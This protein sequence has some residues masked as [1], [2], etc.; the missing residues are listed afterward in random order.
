MLE[1]LPGSHASSRSPVSGLVAAVIL[2]GAIVAVV[3]YS[4]TARGDQPHRL[5][6]VDSLAWSAPI[7]SSPP[8]FP[9]APA[10]AGPLPS[11]PAVDQSS[12]PPLVLGAPS[13]TPVGSSPVATV[14][15]GLPGVGD[16]WDSGVVDERPE[17]LSGPPLVYPEQMRQAGIEGRVLVE[18][19]IDTLGRAEPGS[20]RTVASSQRAFE[21]AATAYVR[22][23]LFRPA[24]VMG[25]PV[26]V[27]IRLPIEFRIAR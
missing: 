18:V 9:E 27:L 25:R 10:G 19:V 15:G 6:V 24:R 14:P 12:L 16:V 5:I 8:R 26:R 7:R 3:L 13:G 23:A 20:L 17:V 2:H 4:H 1:V 22:R 21:A 11:L